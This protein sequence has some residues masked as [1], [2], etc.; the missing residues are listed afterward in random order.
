MGLKINSLSKVG[1]ALVDGSGDPL[2][3]RDTTTNEVGSVTN[4]IGSLATGK[5]FI[6]DG[7]NLPAAQTVSGDFTIDQSGVGTIGTGVIVNA[8]INVAAAIALTKLAATT[9]SR[10]IVSDASGFLVVSSIT[11]TELGYVSGVTSAIQTQLNTKQA[12]I[13]GAA[14]TVVTSNLGANIVA[15]TNGSGKLASS[16]VTATQLGYLSTTT[17]DVQTQLNSRLETSLGVVADGDIAYYNGSAWTNL[18]RGTSGQSLLS[19]GSTIEWGSATVNGI[20]TGGATGQYLAKLSGTDFD[21]DWTDL[22][23]DKVTDVTA[24]V[25]DVNI[26]TGLDTAGVTATELGY[27]NGVTSAI[28]TQLQNKLSNSLAY[29]AIFVGNVTST[30]SQLSAGTNGQLLTI[31]GG[32]P[33]WNTPSATGDV[34][35][36]GS[37][38]DN[39]IARWN[40]TGGNAIQNSGII[41]DDSDNVTGV[42]GLTGTTLTSTGLTTVNSFNIST[43][44]SNDDALTQVL[45]RDAGTG[46]IKYRVASSISGGIA[47]GDYGDIIVSG[48]GTVLTVDNTVITY[49]KIQNVTTDRL[50]GRDTA[51]SGVVEELS[52]SGGVEFTGSGGVQTS[53]FT[54]DVT[55]T[56]GGTATTIANNAVTFAKF[57]SSAVAG[58][59]VIGRSTNSSGVFAEIT[60]GTDGNILRRSGTNIGFGSLDLTASG[61]VGS[62]ILGLANGGTGSATTFTTGSVV[63]AGASG[64]YSQNNSTLFWDNSNTI[65]YVGSNSGAF[66]NTRIDSNG[67]VNSYLQNNITNTSSG[68]AASSDW[69]ATANNGS[70]TT[71]FINVGINSS[72]WSGSGVLDPANQAYLYSP[73]G[74]SVGSSGGSLTL[75]TGGTA[76]TNSRLS[77]SSVGAILIG[78]TGLGGATTR[79]EQWGISTTTGINAVWKDSGGVARATL[80]DEGSFT[81]TPASAKAVTVTQAA[82]GSTNGLKVTQSTNTA[83]IY[84][85]SGNE[86][87]IETDKGWQLGQGASA[88]TS[89]TIN[90]GRTLTLNTF[91]NGDAGAFRFTA[92]SATGTGSND[93][94]KITQS[95]TSSATSNHVVLDPTLTFST[96]SAPALRVLNL[97]PTYALSASV[98]GASVYGI[99][100]SPTLTGLTGTTHYAAVFGSGLSG[101]GTLTPTAK[102]HVK[103]NGI[104]TGVAFQIDNS[105]PT[106]LFKV[107][108]NAN[109]SINA[110]GFGTSAAG[111]L[112]IKNGTAPSTSPADG[113]QLYAEDVASSSELKVRDEAGNTTVL[114]PHHFDQIPDG[115]SEEMAWSFYSERHGKY[116]NVDMLKVVRMVESLTNEQLVFIGNK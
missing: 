100:Y 53:A 12:T 65:L 21:A 27:V 95:Y 16:S 32:S 104:S 39:A 70:D 50:L 93:F 30:P 24:S 81:F 45:V 60:A 8:D 35:G 51:G 40:G 17:S 48:S 74:L 98:S 7:S 89:G 18:A 72:G 19:T 23:L 29:N 77:I 57:Q 44:P 13:T 105:T 15:V 113:I 110:A 33:V 61:T 69:I 108:D 9:A 49:A 5:L 37:S 84:F 102:V 42:V 115:K 82:Q 6:G 114:S 92:S 94:F 99:Y 3:T 66:T 36:P 116:I 83:T 11:S 59:S 91:N 78:T 86:F 79:F 25:D 63:F 58:L 62:S 56:A 31:V 10:A 112:A 80:T 20:P 103:G 68:A 14:S 75:F 38:T 106:E 41:I 22:T 97:S 87:R 1:G 109:V 73:D 34:S 111:V 47:D 71:H 2:L 67:A 96:A 46:T 26:L 88:T 64:V 90:A 52:V 43:I 54:G 107:L 28:Q 85:G 76:S 4:N 55:K 101:F